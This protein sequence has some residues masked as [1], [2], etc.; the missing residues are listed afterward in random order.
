VAIA[1]MLTVI[2]AGTGNFRRFERFALMLCLGSLLLVPILR[3]AHPPVG[4][5]A[6]DLFIPG[7][8]EGRL[9]DVMLMIVGLVGTTVAPWQLFFQQSYVVD[10]GSRLASSPMSAHLW[11]GIILVVIGGI[12]LMA[13]AAAAFAGTVDSGNFTDAGGV[14]VG[15][16]RHVGPLAG[17]LFALALIDASVIG[18]S[19]VSLATAYAIDDALTVRHSL[20]RKPTDAMASTWSMPG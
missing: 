14:T 15:L 18:A 1:A 11:L 5:M 3:M 4:Q 7:L 17:V 16:G 8:P 6:H 20:H 2:G 9:S 19:A 13:F 12:A 10:N